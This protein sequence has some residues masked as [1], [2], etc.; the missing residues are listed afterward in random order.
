MVQLTDTISVQ[1]T[2]VPAGLVL[3]KCCWLRRLTAVLALALLCWVKAMVQQVTNYSHNSS[4][5]ASAY[6]LSVR[7]TSSLMLMRC[8]SSLPVLGWLV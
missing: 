4:M 6:T 7:Q 2:P 1:M 5:A 8:R 3:V